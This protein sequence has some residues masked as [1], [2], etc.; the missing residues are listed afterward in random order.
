MKVTQFV[1]VSVVAG[2]IL[3][4]IGC[5]EDNESYT[6]AN[7]RAASGTPDGAANVERCIECN[8]GYVFDS[9][10]CRLPRYTCANGTAN[11]QTPNGNVDVE[12]CTECATGFVLDSGSDTC[13]REG[14]MYTCENGEAD[15]GTPD[16]TE[17][18]PRCAS[19]YDTYV[20]DADTSAC[21]KPRF[22]CEN[23]V[24]ESNSVPS[25]DVDEPLCVSCDDTYVMDADS[26]A[27]R[28]PMYT[29]ENGEP[30]SNSAPSGDVDEPLCVGCN[31]GYNQV[32]DTTC[33]AN[34]Y[35]CANG[36]Q[37][38]AGT[39]GPDDG[40]PAPDDGDTF[41]TAC[42]LGYFLESAACNNDVVQFSGPDAPSGSGIDLMRI[43]RFPS[44]D[45]VGIGIIGGEDANN[46]IVS[47][48]APVA[49]GA[50][51]WTEVTNRSAPQRDTNTPPTVYDAFHVQAINADTV[52]Y[53]TW[54]EILSYT[55]NHT[56]D[57]SVQANDTGAENIGNFWY[58]IAAESDP[59]DNIWI[60]NGSDLYGTSVSYGTGT[61]GSFANFGLASRDLP[62][63]ANQAGTTTRSSV[64]GH[65]LFVGT[66]L[67]VG[68]EQ[69]VWSG[70]TRE[71]S[72]TWTVYPAFVSGTGQPTLTHRAFANLD[73][74]IYALGDGGHLFGSITPATP[75]YIKMSW[76]RSALR[77]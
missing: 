68:G 53:S 60:G 62:E 3:A 36:M 19:C 76:S 41:C 30:E 64:V 42:N 71:S 54:N 22:T 20:L 17:D 77:L 69:M 56:G 55:V 45:G 49:D 65:P 24:A 37:A 63:V 75:L 31:N 51:R 1:Y 12:E 10:S 32:D 44:G 14:P 16:G 15:M 11:D 67:W 38:A 6:C 21:R 4:L 26:G 7:G 52:Y 58:F 25:G 34:V 27:C 33:A 73:G 59:A 70:D 23:G 5:P 40:T 29:C 35:V 2:A 13:R 57:V 61:G 8:P 50:A 47:Y 43:V 72:I 39:P 28:K 66:T 48:D 46:G 18:V 9:N 74:T